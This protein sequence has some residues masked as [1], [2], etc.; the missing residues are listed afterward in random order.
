MQKYVVSLLHQI[1]IKHTTMKTSISHSNERYTVIVSG[2]EY[3]LT[4]IGESILENGL[5]ELKFCVS[6]IQDNGDET[7][8]IIGK[9]CHKFQ[10]E[11]WNSDYIETIINSERGLVRYSQKCIETLLKIALR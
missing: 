8:N 6:E 1:T 11:A 7:I 10:F 9:G 2:I 3:R 4:N 5:N